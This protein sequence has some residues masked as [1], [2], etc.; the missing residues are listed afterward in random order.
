[1]NANFKYDDFPASFAHC[2]N[3]QCL[4]G[5]SCL[6]RQLALR[7]PKE[8]GGVY[9]II[10][11]SAVSYIVKIQ[12]LGRGAKRGFSPCFFVKSNISG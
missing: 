8:R 6:R 5:D 7:V 2:F 12:S 3:E 11:I 9:T 10:C 4:R 1:M